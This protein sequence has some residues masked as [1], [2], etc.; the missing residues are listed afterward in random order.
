MSG[1]EPEKPVAVVGTTGTIERY[2]TRTSVDNFARSGLNLGNLAF[3][4]AVWTHLA[5]AR[6]VIPFNFIPE[7]VRDRYR[8]ICIPSANYLH[9]HFDFADLAAR[10]EATKLPLLIIGLGIQ[11]SQ[12]LSEVELQP[13]TRRLLSLFAERCETIFVR[14]VHT[15]EY[16]ES[17]GVHNFEALGCPSNF[18]APNPNLG[19]IIARHAAN[20]AETPAE[21][22]T[23]APTFY[24]HNT[25]LE[26]ALLGE[27]GEALTRIVC[28]EPQEAVSLARGTRNRT[29]QHWWENESGFASAL[30]P[31]ERARLLRMMVGYFSVELW[32]EAYR[33][34][35]LVVGTRIHGV[36]LAW[37]AGRPAVLVGHDMRTRELAMAMGLPLM[38]P[39]DA[40][41]AG[42]VERARGLAGE[43]AGRYD[44]HRRDLAVR[45][46][47]LL[48]RHGVTPAEDLRLLA[49]HG[50]RPPGPARTQEEQ[51]AA[52]PP[53]M[54]PPSMGFLE[55]YSRH[56]V[57]GWVRGASAEEAAVEVAFG[58][59]ATVRVVPHTRR[60]DAAADAWQF[61]L[62]PPEDVQQRAP[63]PVEVRHL[64]TG[65]HLAN[66]PAVARFALERPAAVLEGRD[67]VLFL[68]DAAS[69]S[70]AQARGET[71]LDEAGLAQWRAFLL[72]FDELAEMLGF[73]GHV[74]IAPGK[75]VVL[76]DYLPAGQAV[77]ESR[78]ARQIEALARGLGLSRVEV[79]YPLEMLAAAALGEAFSRGDTHWSTRAAGL[80]MESLWAGAFPPPGEVLYP[81]AREAWQSVYR[82]GDLLLLRG[83]VTVEP[84]MVCRRPRQSQLLS[85]VRNAALGMQR[86][87]ASTDPRAEGRAVLFH[88]WLGELMVDP[89]SEQF[90]LSTAIFAQ[91]LDSEL[92]EAAMP[93]VVVFEMAERFLLRAPRVA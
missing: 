12:S 2:T 65:T 6:E 42:L 4:H 76:A 50:R 43:V 25:A 74:L 75:E 19:R 38:T 55:R 66:S 69:D 34:S 47:E 60:P 89:V 51:V 68:S 23:F 35:D 26:T 91:D 40:V 48:R 31:A 13:G 28:Q 70:L 73:H 71:V 18:L 62:C 87:F 83:N 45:Y 59:G 46:V 61:S 49:M 79:A 22:I 36:S 77:R 32:I 17:Q 1:F 37:Q 58:D 78:P 9:R 8:L 16:L 80:A 53:P 41:E 88:D 27:I 56:A 7:E 33:R 24:P 29:L 57:A 84:R 72:A 21:R 11:A 81:V 52:L 85:S 63:V 92:V 14:G 15:G 10:L 5:D 67:G 64:A 93:D 82:P 30:A 20:L 3:Q 90:R 54:V 86:R 44:A 39:Q